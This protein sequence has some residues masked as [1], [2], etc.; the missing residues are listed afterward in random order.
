MLQEVTSNVLNLILAAE[1]IAETAEILVA[2]EAGLAETTAGTT[3]PAETEAVIAGSEAPAVDAETTVVIDGIVGGEAPAGD[4]GMTA[5]IATA[6]AE[7]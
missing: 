1:T 3:G 5:E 2:A 7:S 6:G 4:A